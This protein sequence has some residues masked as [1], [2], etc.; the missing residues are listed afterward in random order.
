MFLCS[1]TN[2][3]EMEPAMVSERQKKNKNTDI[4]ERHNKMNNNYFH[5]RV[6]AT[7]KC[8]VV[9]DRIDGWTHSFIII[10]IIHFIE[11]A[12]KIVLTEFVI[13]AF[14]AART[15]CGSVRAPSWKRSA[16]MET[17]NTRRADKRRLAA[18]SKHLENRN[19][20]ETSRK[21]PVSSVGILF[22]LTL[23]VRTSLSS[24]NDTVI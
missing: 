21:C 13:V 4:S 16:E 7:T 1:R 6:C 22:A 24:N 12:V 9:L 14:C 18:F 11:S 3:L 10:I 2:S 23:L 8:L 17:S 5:K 15:M 19:L 20:R